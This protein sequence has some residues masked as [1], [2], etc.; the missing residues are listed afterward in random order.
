M[1]RRKEPAK[2]Q[3]GPLKVSFLRFARWCKVQLE[4]G[5]KVY[6]KVA[7]DGVQPK[8]LP[9]EE[10]EIARQLF[11]DIDTVSERKRKLIA[12]VCGARSGKSY[13]MGALCMLW[14]AVTV[15]LSKLAPGQVAGALIQAPD[16]ELA[17]EQLN[18]V[19]G[20]VDSSGLAGAVVKRDSQRVRFV[21]GD[22]KL[23]EVV[24]RAIGKGGTGG[25]GRTLVGA[26]LDEA[27]FL[28]TEG[29]VVNDLDAYRA[30][31]VRIVPGGIMVICS[32]PWVRLGLLYEL[33]RNNHGKD[34]ETC[35]S[36]HAPT[37]VFRVDP[38]ILL[39]VDE[40]YEHDPDNAEREFGA[41]FPENG[42]ARFFGEAEVERAS[43][44]DYEL[45][46]TPKVG[47]VLTAGG[48]LGLLR[49]SSTLVLV[50]HN[51]DKTIEV[52]DVLEL[53]PEPG[54]P[55]KL[56]E[57]CKAFAGRM[58]RWGV[59][60]I[61]A[62]G[63]NREAAREY[64]SM[65]GIR[66]VDAPEGARGKEETYID[67]RVKFREGR[68]RLPQHKRL[69]LQL[70]EVRST[71]NISG[72]LSIYSPRRPDGSHGDVVSAFVLAAF[73]KWGDKVVEPSAIDG[74]PDDERRRIREIERRVRPSSW[75]SSL[76]D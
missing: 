72:R 43:A 61:M 22:G 68:V 37:R 31:K 50:A 56:S 24:V 44:E 66:I 20:L 32:T 21:R 49:N 27:N 47:A 41:I 17:T 36:V 64:L 1:A 46:R 62:D 28:N 60:A 45:P 13:I 51:P 54:E 2:P 5:Q 7:F 52:I 16:K 48:D 35:L 30:A 65:A 9:P 3:G 14:L 8:D 23:V 38:D 12:A 33:H 18:Y 67:T 59:T 55:L 15:D 42:S 53:R 71:H 10:R 34:T 19:K 57:V 26:C 73:K 69:L 70:S 29:F 4:P 58:L 74:L 40:A 63:H 25:R 11:G 76:A 6:A 75:G 39:T